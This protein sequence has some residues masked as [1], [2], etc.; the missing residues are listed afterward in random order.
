LPRFNGNWAISQGLKWV[1]GVGHSLATAQRIERVQI[2]K[3]G[4]AVA[5]TARH[6]IMKKTRPVVL[7]SLLAL[8]VLVGAVAAQ[9]SS[10]QQPPERPMTEEA[11]MPE[12]VD[13]TATAIVPPAAAQETGGHGAV[14]TTAPQRSRVWVV[15]DWFDRGGPFMWPI[16]FC[17]IIAV[18]FIIER[19]ITLVRA[20]TNTRTLMSDILNAVR[21]EGVPAAERVCEQTRGPIAAIVFSGLKQADRGP[22]AVEK[23]IETAGAVEMSFLERGLIWLATIATIAPLLGFL[24]TVS[25]MIRAFDAIAAADQV[26][27]KLVAGGISE[28]LITTQAGLLIAVPTS[29]FHNFFLSQIDRFVVEMEESSSELVNTIDELK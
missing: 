4:A 1:C 26:S 22:D 20:R 29:L 18:T 2:L 6:P 15:L 16:L 12:A 23:A 10:T 25:G 9:Q 13:T 14:T 8:T 17:S 21:R 28:A 19:S 3:G 5:P 11:A 27:A 7:I 24:G